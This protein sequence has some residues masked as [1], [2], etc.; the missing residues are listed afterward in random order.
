MP[1]L[2]AATTTTTTTTTAK[3]YNLTDCCFSSPPTC[4]AIEA[5][6]PTCPLSHSWWKRRPL[7]WWPHTACVFAS[8]SKS[9]V[10]L[11]KQLWEFILLQKKQSKLLCKMSSK[12]L[13]FSKSRTKIEKPRRILIFAESGLLCMPIEQPKDIQALRK[14]CSEKL[15]TW[16]FA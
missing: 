6:Q 14:K 2:H 1:P 10:P 11:C 16:E 15:V 4:Q 9:M 5:N 3:G 7:S 13:F 12:K 8:A